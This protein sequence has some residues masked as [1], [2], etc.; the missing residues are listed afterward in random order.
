[1]STAVLLRPR[2]P[3]TAPLA[4]PGRA[5][6]RDWVIEGARVRWL[7]ARETAHGLDTTDH[8]AILAIAS[9][10]HPRRLLA[11]L[12]GASRSPVYGIRTMV[13][14]VDVV[15]PA[16]VAS[17]G[18]VT[19]TV[20]PSADASIVTW[21]LLMERDELIR[22]A[23]S[24][25]LGVDFDLYSLPEVT[26]RP[27][28]ARGSRRPPLAFVHRNGPLPFPDGRPRALWRVR[29]LRGGLPRA[30]I[31]AA[32]RRAAHLLGRSGCAWPLRP[33]RCTPSDRAL[34]P[35]GLPI[36]WPETARLNDGP[37]L[38]RLD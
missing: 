26:A 17:Y 15:Y 7:D 33:E 1:M 24:E 5:P 11:H 2:T 3:V 16:N 23:A 37:E 18:V 14:G 35:F 21:L 31:N 19:A 25:R 8:I 36:T 38:T 22:V 27:I 13:A 32:H 10:R 28:H 29:K 12:G 6:R 34:A 4:Y 30:S 9:N 20:V